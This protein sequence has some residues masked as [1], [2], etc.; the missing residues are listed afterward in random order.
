MPTVFHRVEGPHVGPH[1]KAWGAGAS[2]PNGH[3]IGPEPEEGA[4]VVC[5]ACGWEGTATFSK[6]VRKETG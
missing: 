1:P 4:R 6:A 3:L 5:A 2:C